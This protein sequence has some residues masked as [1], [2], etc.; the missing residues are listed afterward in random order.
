[1]AHIHTN[2]GAHDQTITAYIIKLSDDE[3]KALLHMHR[4][5]G[6]LLPLG[7]HIELIETPWQAAS[8]EI[9]EESGYEMFQLQILQPVERL[10][11]LAGAELHPYPVALNTHRIS[12]D[13]FH[14]DIAYA[15]VTSE[16][17][18]NKPE[19]G[20]STDLRWVSLGELSTLTENEIFLSAKALYE[21]VF[22]TCL[23]TWEKVPTSSFR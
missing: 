17:P 23:P 16:E 5:L 8:H 19:D 21:F 20:E 9:P 11:I 10:K 12:S 1:M 14:S 4:K 13:H 2:P 7:G 6:K 3:P 15:F 22:E 18:K